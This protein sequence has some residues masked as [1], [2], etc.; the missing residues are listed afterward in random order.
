MT[1]EELPHTADVMFRVTAPDKCDLFAESVRALMLTMYGPAERAEKGNIPRTVEV[2][3]PDEESLLQEFLSEVLYISEVDNLV[4]SA[5]W[6][7]I[8]GMHLSATLEGRPFDPL[9][10]SMGT[11]VKGISFSGLHILKEGGVYVL[12]IIFDV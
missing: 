1:I 9:T 12:D 3:A 2:D 7:C 4:F 5:A 11:E 6:V 10:D 8:E